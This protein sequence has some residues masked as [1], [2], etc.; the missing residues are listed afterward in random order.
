MAREANTLKTFT[1]KSEASRNR[2]LQERLGLKD[3]ELF[4]KCPPPALVAGKP[5]HLGRAEITGNPRTSAS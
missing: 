1:S 2:D 5:Q 3:T 4:T